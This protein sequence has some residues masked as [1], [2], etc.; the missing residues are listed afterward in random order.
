MANRWANRPEPRPGQ[1]KLY[2]HILLKDYPE[3]Q[4]IAAAGQEKLA[5][6][7][8]L[9][10]TPKQWLHITT[11]V[12]GFR[13]RFSKARIEDMLGAAAKL[14]S[15]TP[16]I[17]ISLGSVLYHPEAIVLRVQPD[18]ALD[19]VYSAVEAATRIASSSDET[20]EHQSWSPHV[21]LAYSTSVQAAG[22]IINALGRKLP[23]CEITID[24]I[25]LV[26]QEGAERQ[27]NWRPVGEVKL[28]NPPGRDCRRSTPVVA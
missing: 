8:G 12:V 9:H 14:L 2:W 17:M 28:G 25:S 5:G 22:P 13:D 26:V 18:D 21:T 24:R 4:A 20:T 11:L 3:V 7:R 27:W 15:D 19:P 10:F 6:F 1:G 16:P 23:S